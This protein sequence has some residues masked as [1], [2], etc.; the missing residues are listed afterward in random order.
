[1]LNEGEVKQHRKEAARRLEEIR[2][3][4][5]DA[6]NQKEKNPVEEKAKEATVEEME[7]MTPP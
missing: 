3:R 4:M 6:K 7:K 2:K 5:R 1:M